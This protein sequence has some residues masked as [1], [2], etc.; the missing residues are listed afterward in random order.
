MVR[1]TVNEFEQRMY[2]MQSI[3]AR[4]TEVSLDRRLEQAAPIKPQLDSTRRWR[5][6]LSPKFRRV[7]SAGSLLFQVVGIAGYAGYFVSM[8]TLMRVVS[9]VLVAATW[10]AIYRIKGLSS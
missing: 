9:G 7:L 3:P 4:L 8:H 10:Y 6:R 2:G 1:K 5:Q